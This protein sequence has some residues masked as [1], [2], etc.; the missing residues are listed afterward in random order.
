MLQKNMPVHSW[1]VYKFGDPS[2]QHSAR[3]VK[4]AHGSFPSLLL[5]A[6]Y[7]LPSLNRDDNAFQIPII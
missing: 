1:L 4:R 6:S 3:P 5:S 7:P 2:L